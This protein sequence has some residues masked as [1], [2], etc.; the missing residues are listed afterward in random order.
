MNDDRRYPFH[1]VPLSL[2]SVFKDLYTIV[3]EQKM[4]KMLDENVSLT[5]KT[6]RK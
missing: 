4:T 5:T 6:R 2:S 3:W 1:N